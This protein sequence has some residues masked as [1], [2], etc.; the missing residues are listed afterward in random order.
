MHDIPKHHL[1]VNALI[2]I[3]AVFSS[4]PME[5]RAQT[6]DLSGEWT[7]EVSTSQGTFRP[8]WTI[9]QNGQDLNVSYSSDVLGSG[10]FTGKLDGISVFFSFEAYLQGQSVPLVYQGTVDTDGKMTGEMDL[11]GGM[12][13]GTFTA[14]RSDG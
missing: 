2:I 5:T 4:N 13:T 10:N 1:I 6:V 14:T 11:A 9:V 7:L 3:T 8:S 12:V